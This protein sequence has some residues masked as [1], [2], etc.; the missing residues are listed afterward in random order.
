MR[1][2]GWALEALYRL[3]DGLAVLL[4]L[5][6]LLVILAQVAGRFLGFVVPSAL[7]LAGF[8]TAGLI[9]LGLAPTLRAGGH[10]R[11]VALWQRLPP[12]SRALVERLSLLLSLLAA[13]YA[14][15]QAWGRVGESLR[16]GDLAPGLLP[17]PLWIPLAVVAFGVSV[18][19]LAL[20][21]ALLKTFR[22][23]RT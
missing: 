8:A 2:L 16:Y 9:F 7:E 6:I 18:F 20:L 12:G 23:G 3:A 10:V 1:V 14:A 4:G 22:G 17:L 15:L 13:L 11:V 19:A 5:F 21:E